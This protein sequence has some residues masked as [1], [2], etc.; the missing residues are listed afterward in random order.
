MNARDVKPASSAA[1]NSNVHWPD[2][3]GVPLI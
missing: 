3:D 2:E 1:V